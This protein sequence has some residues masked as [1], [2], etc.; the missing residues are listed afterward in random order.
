MS[1]RKAA[2][3]PKARPYSTLRHAAVV[4]LVLAV[5]WWSLKGTETSVSEVIKGLPAMWDFLTRMLPPDLAILKRLP[6]PITETIQIAIL[7]TTIGLILAFPLSFLGARNFTPRRAICNTVRWLFNT[8]RGVNEFVYAL[9]FTA[10]AGLGPFAGVLALSVHTAGALGK[11]I[12]EAIENMDEEPV[13]AI[14]ATGANK[15]QIAFQGMLPEL[16]PSFLSYVLY[17]WEHNI[18]AATVLGL[19][20]AGGIG[21]ELLTSMK[22]FKYQEVATIVI[23]MLVL[24]TVVDQMSAMVR[25][26]VVA[27]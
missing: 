8:F 26:K 3:P 7:G 22:L 24:I 1:A 25:K 20:G 18:R 2:D 6:K 10:V 12:S 5:Y 15:V 21:I 4:A 9:M 27:G 14:V 17:Y 16:L 11:Y 19:V 13:K 23:V